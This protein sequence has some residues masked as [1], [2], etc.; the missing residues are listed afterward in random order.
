MSALRDNIYE[1]LE[2]HDP[3]I[4]RQWRQ[5]YQSPISMATPAL[6]LRGLV[7]YFFHIFSSMQGDFNRELNCIT[8]NAHCVEHWVADFKTVIAPSFV[9]NARYIFAPK[10]DIADNISEL[11]N[12]LGAL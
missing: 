4:A 3:M 6:E 9:R 10:R 5:T 1:V 7:D 2:A 11:G 8:G 12:L